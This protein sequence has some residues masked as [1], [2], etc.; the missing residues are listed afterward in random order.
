VFIAR[1]LAAVALVTPCATFAATHAF[2]VTTSSCSGTLA[3]SFTDGVS[4]SCTGDFS[5]NGGLIESSQSVFLAATGALSLVGVKVTA[6]TITF[7]SE[8]S[9]SIDETSSITADGV[10]LLSPSAL[11][12]G[13]IRLNGNAVIAHTIGA[14]FTFNVQPAVV[15]EPHALALLMAGLLSAGLAMARQRQKR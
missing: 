3:S 8:T 14:P 6:P 7:Q 2:N 15:P 9:L 10:D 13:P 5:L 11:P 4:L 1:F 12:T